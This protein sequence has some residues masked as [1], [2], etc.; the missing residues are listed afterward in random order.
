VGQRPTKA[1]AAYRKGDHTKYLLL[2][3]EKR[4]LKFYG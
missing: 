3:F 1:F 2:S 4:A